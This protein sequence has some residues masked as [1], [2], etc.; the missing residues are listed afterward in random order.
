M[1]AFRVAA[2][3]WVHSLPL[4][5]HYW[6]LSYLISALTFVAVNQSVLLSPLLLDVSNCPPLDPFPI[7]CI[8]LK[9]QIKQISQI[10]SD[11]KALFGS[12]CEG[13]IKKGVTSESLKALGVIKRR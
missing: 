8:L 5:W 2:F 13:W 7:N 3:V 4:F 9:V 10:I 1:I 6:H 12:Y 11:M